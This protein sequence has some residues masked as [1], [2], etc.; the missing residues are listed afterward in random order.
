MAIERRL[1]ISFILGS[2]R[3]RYAHLIEN[4]QNQ[5]LQGLTAWPTTLTGAFNLLVNWTY[6]PK[7][8]GRG[9]MS[10]NDGIS[11]ANVDEDED[12]VALANAGGTKRV[13]ADKSK[14]TLWRQ[15]GALRPR[16]YRRWK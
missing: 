11:F 12:G 7:N 1:A 5:H 15:E 10:A 13:R 8:A 16:M 6:D 14:V 2:D 3:S 4:L 9:T